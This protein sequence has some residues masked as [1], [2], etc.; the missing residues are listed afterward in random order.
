MLS[1][2]RTGSVAFGRGNGIKSGCGQGSDRFAVGGLVIFGIERRGKGEEPLVRSD[3]VGQR[4]EA[5]RSSDRNRGHQEVVNTVCRTLAGTSVAACGPL[6]TLR[7]ASCNRVV[8][9]PSNLPECRVI[10][11]PNRRSVMRNHCR[12]ERL[13]VSCRW[14]PSH[15]FLHRAVERMFGQVESELEKAQPSFR[16]LHLGPGQLSGDTTLPG[17]RDGACRC[18]A[19]KP[20]QRVASA[21]ALSTVIR[22]RCPGGCGQPAIQPFAG[23]GRNIHGMVGQRVDGIIL[24]TVG[25][26]PSLVFHE[27]S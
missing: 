6:H 3:P 14:A 17:S 5:Q 12:E 19:E 8:P 11:H 2:S 10:G 4:Q 18:H 26:S 7:S 27:L 21:A 1:V 24:L 23:S 22:Q 9:A 16:W 15:N 20:T 25:L 13:G